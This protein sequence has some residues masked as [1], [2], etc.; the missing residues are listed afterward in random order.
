MRSVATPKVCGAEYLGEYRIFLTF[1]DGKSGV[2][3]LEHELWGEVFEPLRDVGLF[4]RFRFV[5]ELDTIVWPTGADLAPE[6]L[7]ENAVTEEPR[8]AVESAV[9]Q[10]SG[11]LRTGQRVPAR[12]AGKGAGLGGMRMDD[13]ITVSVDADVADA[14]RAAS[15]RDR[16]KLDLL[17][18]LRLREETHSERALRDV[19]QDI[20]RNAQQ[21]GLT[22][23]VLRAILNE[24]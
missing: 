19:M 23:E 11:G 12:P 5:P 8:P 21:R 13:R 9:D 24:E 18:N 16:R 15:D 17:I 1:E 3:D 10:P 2:I 20:S 22:P 6:Y 4:R 14:Y 7:Y